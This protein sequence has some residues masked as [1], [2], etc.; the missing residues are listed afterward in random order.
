MPDYRPNFVNITSMLRFLH[1]GQFC[2]RPIGKSAFTRLFFSYVDEN[3][4]NKQA[5]FQFT[6]DSGHPPV[7]SS[8][9][10]VDDT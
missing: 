9:P 4:Q 8:L 2:R 5:G 6:T 1:S 7:V 10:Y 3:G